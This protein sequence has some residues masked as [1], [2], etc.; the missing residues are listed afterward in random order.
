MKSLKNLTAKIASRGPVALVLSVVISVL[1]ITGLV[2]AVTTISTNISTDGTLSVGGQSTLGGQA[3]TTR[4]SINE[5]AYFG[6]TATTTFGIDGAG[7]IGGTFRVDGGLSRF[8]QASSTRFSVHDM[9]YFG[10]TA[11]TTIGGARGNITTT[12]TNSAT[13]T[14]IIGCIQM[15]ATSTDTA[16]R[17]V[18][19]ANAWATST[20]HTAVANGLMA[21]QYGSCPI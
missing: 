5:T 19:G 14:L 10:G 9:A 20:T 2:Q 6:G 21:W 17:L 13:T 15:N 12:T 8:S 4:L 3:S 7:I 1:F 16:I 18:P 11:T